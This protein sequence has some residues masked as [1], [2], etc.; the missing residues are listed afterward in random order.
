MLRKVPVF[1]SSPRQRGSSPPT[2]L[3]VSQKIVEL[4]VRT[5]SPPFNEMPAFFTVPVSNH[6]EIMYLRYFLIPRILSGFAFS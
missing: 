3:G 2:E 4:F 5:Y 1:S 6:F